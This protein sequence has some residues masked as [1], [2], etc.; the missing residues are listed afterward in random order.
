MRAAVYLPWIPAGLCALV[1]WH[2]GIVRLVARCCRS[3]MNQMLKHYPKMQSS[4]DGACPLLMCAFASGVSSGDFYAPKDKQQGATMGMPVKVLE[5]GVLAGSCPEWTKVSAHYKPKG[6]VLPSAAP[7]FFTNPRTT[8]YG[9]GGERKSKRELWQEERRRGGGPGLH[10][11]L[12]GARAAAGRGVPG[13]DGRG[14]ELSFCAAAGSRWRLGRAAAAGSRVAPQE[15]GSP[16]ERLC[17]LSRRRR[18]HTIAR[19]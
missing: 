10:G 7:F 15:H 13:C 1:C 14:N 17:W 16:A 8:G 3:W 12:H 19:G 6:S 11:G 4:A 2:A 5:G 9:G 18:R